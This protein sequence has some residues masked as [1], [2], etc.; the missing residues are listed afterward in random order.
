[1]CVYIYYTYIHM[2]MYILTGFKALSL[3][4]G[5]YRFIFEKKEVNIHFF[6][7]IHFL[8]GLKK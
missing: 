7:N 1:M 8:V 6:L 5:L 2:Y 4:V 3:Y